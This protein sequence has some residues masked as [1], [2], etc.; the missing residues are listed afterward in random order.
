MVADK[1]GIAPATLG[2]VNDKLIYLAQ[3]HLLNLPC[4]GG[5]TSEGRHS[6]PTAQQQSSIANA[7][8]V[9]IS[10]YPNPANSTIYFQFPPSATTIIRM[11]DVSS[12]M[13]SEQVIKD[14]S[15]ASFNVKD[16]S[17]GLYIYQVIPF[18]L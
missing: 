14:N 10:A 12:R 13:L 9:D 15:T 7:S 16:Y 17:S 2:N 3:A 18:R 6:A 1:P 5:R 8:P 4:C 11:F